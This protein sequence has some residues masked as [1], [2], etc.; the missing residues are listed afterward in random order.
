MPISTRLI[1]HFAA[2][3]RLRHDI[4]YHNT[5]HYHRHN[6]SLRHEYHRRRHAALSARAMPLAPCRFSFDAADFA[7]LPFRHICHATRFA[8]L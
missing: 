3:L 2:M 8:R 5:R 4:Y 6:I 1:R 7:M